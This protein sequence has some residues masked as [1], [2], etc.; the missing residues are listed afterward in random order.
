MRT[1]GL[2]EQ[3]WRQAGPFTPISQVRKEGLRCDVNYKVLQLQKEDWNPGPPGPA[4]ASY[5]AHG[6][7]VLAQDTHPG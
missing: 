4:P 1:R 2:S 6:A 5:M 3:C 7:A